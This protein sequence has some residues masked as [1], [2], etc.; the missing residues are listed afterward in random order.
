M[1]QPWVRHDCSSGWLKYN[2]NLRTA[3][4]PLWNNCM[5]TLSCSAIYWY[6]PDILAFDN[7][8]TGLYYTGEFCGIGIKIP[9]SSGEFRGIPKVVRKAIRKFRGVPGDRHKFPE[10]PGSSGGSAQIPWSSGMPPNPI[11]QPSL[12]GRPGWLPPPTCT[13]TNRIPN[14]QNVQPSPKPSFPDRVKTSRKSK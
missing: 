14:F 5:S 8:A 13:L 11:T 10:V 3:K 4:E 6:F 7:T 1:T 12:T 9:R 2:T